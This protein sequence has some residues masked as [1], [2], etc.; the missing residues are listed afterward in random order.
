MA[1]NTFDKTF[2]KDFLAT[3]PRNPG[4]Y[5]FVGP[6]DKVVYV[7][8]AKD[9]RARLSQY[10]L[11][12]R[13]KAHRKMKRIVKAGSRIEFDVTD[14]EQDALLLENKLIQELRP[15]LNV[16]GAYSFMYP[17][18]GLKREGRD[19]DLAYSTEPEHMEAYAFALFGSYRS[20]NVTK[21]S[22]E[23]LVQILA[24]LGHL[25]STPER[26]PYTS[27]RRFR[28]IPKDLDASLSSFLLGDSQAFLEQAILYLLENPDARDKASEVQACMDTLK[29]F[30]AIECVKLAR[31]RESEACDYIP[32]GER[33]PA[34]IRAQ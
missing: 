2:G 13:I 20:R 9:L 29:S 5:R 14:T 8:K 18:L 19:L 23:A 31:L 30:Y 26:L 25:D 28:Q 11:A 3:V 32:Q 22:F 34:S 6:T 12:K 33:D 1:L 7:G 17:S 24:W 21:T 4:V 16:A 10:R 15:R 27:W